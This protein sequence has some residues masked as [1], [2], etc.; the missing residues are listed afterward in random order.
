[1][2]NIESIE[3]GVPGRDADSRDELRFAG[4]EPQGAE[5]ALYLLQM[6]SLFRS[7]QMYYRIT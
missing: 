7:G 6:G 2:S 4:L 1:M 5:T 3:C